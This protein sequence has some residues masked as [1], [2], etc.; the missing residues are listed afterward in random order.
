M[1]SRT[2]IAIG[3][4]SI[5]GIKQ[6]EQA[7][8]RL[9]AKEQVAVVAVSPWFETTPVG[10]AETRFTNGVVE[11]AAALLPR[12]LL[13]HLQQ[14]ERDLGRVSGDR[15]GARV[16]DLDLLACGDRQHRDEC[17][18]LP[19]PSLWY[20]R[21]VLDPWERIAADWIVPRWEMSVADLRQRLLQRPLPVRLAGGIADLRQAI[22]DDMADKFDGLLTITSATDQGPTHSGSPAPPLCI[23]LGYLSRRTSEIGDECWSVNLTELAADLQTTELAA[24][25]FVLTAAL[26]EPREIR[27]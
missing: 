8:D 2:F 3:T 6:V 12:E 17:L 19:H 25:G 20:R 11:V 23:S 10:T 9:G 24:A 1:N 5:D 21:F 14:I 27:G 4:S 22:A 13:E 26:D 16:V 7:V 18:T 15:W